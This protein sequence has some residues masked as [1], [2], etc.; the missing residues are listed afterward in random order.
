MKKNLFTVICFFLA[1]FCFCENGEK[2][3]LDID[4]AVELALKNN[5]SLAQSAISLQAAERAKN[6]SWNSL[7]PSVS[8]GA[9][10]SIPIAGGNAEYSS[11]TSFS[12]GVSVS[13]AA[14]V[15]STIKNAKLSYEAGRISFDDALKSV[16]LSVRQAF[17]TLVY[18]EEN[19]ALQ[20]ENLR[21][22]KTQYENNLAKY[23]SGRLSEV[24]ALSAEVNYKAKIPL[25]ESARTSYLNSLDSFKLLLGL[26]LES[27]IELDGE[28]EDSLELSEITVD[29]KTISPP[30]LKE[31]EN[32]IEQAK[33]SVLARRFSAYAPTLKASASYR[34]G[35]LLTGS[36]EFSDLKNTASAELSVSIPLDGLFPWSSLNDAVDS[37][38][39]NVKTLELQFENEKKE[40]ERSV[41]SSLRQIKQCQESI[42]YKQANIILAQ[43]TLD[44]TQEAYNRGT[45][46]LLTLENAG[47]TLLNAK[48]SLNSDILSLKNL[49]LSLEKTIGVE[50]GSL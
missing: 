33:I 44:M 43:K 21:L 36:E 8:L 48:V 39:D 46:D 5:V 35:P 30:V 41:Q 12:A 4:G 13:F 47:T 28:M 2:L 6:H 14:N 19:I 11:S 32:K 3:I 31:L 15:Y 37:A 49:I 42:R 17:Y 9:A 7:S 45:K 50:F 18:A 38:S 34:L 23:N 29:E 26:D 20:E 40:L 25:V 27:E 16:E 10:S 1:S 24:D 22:A